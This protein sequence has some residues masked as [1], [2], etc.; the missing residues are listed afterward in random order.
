MSGHDENEAN[1]EAQATPDFDDD[2]QGKL[3]DLLS[4]AAMSGIFAAI[5]YPM[6]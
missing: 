2:F 5:P 1:H 3:D 6:N 4:G